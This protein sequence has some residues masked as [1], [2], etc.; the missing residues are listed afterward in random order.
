MKVSALGTN[1]ALT[2]EDLC[3]VFNTTE[4]SACEKY[5]TTNDIDLAV[6]KNYGLISG[7][8]S[9]IYCLGTFDFVFNNR[10]AFWG[11]P[12]IDQAVV[13]KLQANPLA[14]LPTPIPLMH[15]WY[16]FST[17]NDGVKYHYHKVDFHTAEEKSG[18]N[19]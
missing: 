18:E 13:D 8:K 6:N 12:A 3:V 5:L 17:A 11:K 7:F 16:D 2:F 9:R 19:E 4:F 10:F 14:E 1:A 15:S